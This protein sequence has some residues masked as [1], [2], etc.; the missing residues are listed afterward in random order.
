M[1]KVA[2]G[3]GF[4]RAVPSR[5]VG[6]SRYKLLGLGCPEGRPG[7]EYIACV[8][9]FSRSLLAVGPEKIVRQGMYPLSAV[10]VP[11][12]FRFPLSVSFHQY[13]IFIHLS[14]TLYYNLSNLQWRKIIHIKIRSLLNNP[15]TIVPFNAVKTVV[16]TASLSKP[17]INK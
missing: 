2:L 8:L 12:Y 5:R 4:L 16:L 17:C 9:I 1:G 13:S 11:K 15:R 7:P 3:Q 6:G 14:R 10:P